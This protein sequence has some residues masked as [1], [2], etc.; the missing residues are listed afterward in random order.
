MYGP[1]INL[2]QLAGVA[3]MT[4]I[5]GAHGHSWIDGLKVVSGGN[6]GPFQ[7]T[8]TTKEGPQGAG[9]GFIRAYQGHVDATA[10]YLIT[11][12]KLDSNICR[13]SQQQ[14]PTTNTPKFPRVSASPGDFIQ[15]TYLENGHISKPDAADGTPGTIYWFGT[16]NAKPDD[17]LANVKQWT[18]DGKGGDGRGRLLAN[19]SNFDDG[20]CAE[21]NDTPIAKQRKAAGGG[22]A[23]KSVFKLPEDAKVG[24]TFTVYWVWDYSNHFG[25][26]KK[27]HT[28]WYT[29]CIDIQ[30]VAP[31]GKRFWRGS[32][33]FRARL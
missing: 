14:N 22:G 12:P 13:P 28:E 33:K 31:K 30:V 29:S 4:L 7:N 20:K 18:V 1:T 11:T 9:I 3:A 2:F 15:G 5:S 26:T 23:C 27:G 6:S 10:V 32:A 25:P 24:S 16:A 8:T 21:T 19:P 17:T